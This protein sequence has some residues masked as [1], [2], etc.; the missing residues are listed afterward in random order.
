L[1]EHIL[2]GVLAPGAVLRQE[3]IARRFHASRTPVREAVARLASEGLVDASTRRSV[4]VT[5]LSI[6]DFV[7]INQLRL[8]LEP[9]AA[10]ISAETMP[11][12]EIDRLEERLAAVSGIDAISSLDQ[13]VHHSIALHCRNGRVARMI[14]E[15]NTCMG[16]ARVHDLQGRHSEVL[17]DLKGIISALRAR[18]GDLAATLMREH[19]QDFYSLIAPSPGSKRR[20]P[21]PSV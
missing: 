10:G 8:L 6:H 7:E 3:E 11:D 12:A 14:D 15:A 19:I 20:A 5:E 1:R 13:D 4:H 21:L 2:S 9:F 17:D 18:D 16:I